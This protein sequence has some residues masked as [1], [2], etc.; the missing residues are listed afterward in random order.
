MADTAEV[1]R[2]LGDNVARAGLEVRVAR[3]TPTLE[4]AAEALYF[5]LGREYREDVRPSVLF[6]LLPRAWAH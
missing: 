4:V 2:K 6:K 5:K 1:V 3:E